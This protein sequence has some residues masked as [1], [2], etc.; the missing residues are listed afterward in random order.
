[1]VKNTIWEQ[2][3]EREKREL[4]RGVKEGRERERGKKNISLFMAEALFF[5]P[6]SPP[7]YAQAWPTMLGHSQGPEASSSLLR[8]RSSLASYAGA[9][10][11]AQAWLPTLERGLSPETSLNSG[12]K[13]AWVWLVVLK[14][15]PSQVQNAKRTL[16]GVLTFNTTWSQI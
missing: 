1:M 2:F 4:E 10:P 15:T 12:W 3:L 14:Y 5:I 9:S 7:H 13:H 11:N 6:F 16:L 8:A